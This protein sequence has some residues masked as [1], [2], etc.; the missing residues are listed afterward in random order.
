MSEDL[1]RLWAIVAFSAVWPLYAHSETPREFLEPRSVVIHAECAGNESDSSKTGFGV[2]LNENGIV[3]SARHIFEIEGCTTSIRFSIRQVSRA[4]KSR[5]EVPYV[6]GSLDFGNANV[7]NAIRAYF[8]GTS[9]GRS[10]DYIIFY[11]DQNFPETP[12]ANLVTEANRAIVFNHIE[13]NGAELIFP[14]L[15]RINSDIEDLDTS[16]LTWEAKTSKIE[17]NRELSLYFSGLNE[18]GNSGGGVFVRSTGDFVGLNVGR[19]KKRLSDLNAVFKNRLL[20]ISV[21]ISDIERA[22]DAAGLTFE[23]KI[24]SLP[25]TVTIRDFQG[26]EFSNPDSLAGKVSALFFDDP[27]SNPR[28]HTLVLLDTKRDDL[29]TERTAR[30]YSAYLDEFAKAKIQVPGPINDKIDGE[31]IHRSQE[32]SSSAILEREIDLISIEHPNSFL[33]SF[34]REIKRLTRDRDRLVSANPCDKSGHEHVLSIL[35]CHSGLSKNQL[36]VIEELVS[37]FDFLSEKIGALYSELNEH[38]FYESGSDEPFKIARE[39]HGDIAR[40]LFKLGDFPSAKRHADAYIAAIDQ[41]EP[42]D[43]RRLCS[44]N[45]V[46][47]A[48]REV[49]LVLLDLSSSADAGYDEDHWSSIIREENIKSFL[50]DKNCFLNYPTTQSSQE[51]ALRKKFYQALDNEFARIATGNNISYCGVIYYFS[52]PSNQGIWNSVMSTLASLKLAEKIR[53]D[54]REPDENSSANQIERDYRKL[55]NLAGRRSDI[56]DNGCRK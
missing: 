35:N 34:R 29:I 21:M 24:I 46:K 39:A 26:V 48:Y 20:P 44:Y 28:A 14:H 23:G 8:D 4:S 40:L 15:G 9:A 52:D 31:I 2:I 25:V 43:L 22:F 13:Q 7:V 38:S 45:N 42:G 16:S 54:A 10:F 3:A 33:N 36:N 1:H 41:A 49:W 37:E 32:I 30:L 19:D 5:Y 51:R 53:I 12:R 18:P 6:D 56:P 27:E 47:R 17:H 50:E 11:L 55:K